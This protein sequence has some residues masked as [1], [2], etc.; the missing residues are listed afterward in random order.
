MRTRTLWSSIAAVVACALGMPGAEDWPQVKYDSER[1][2]NL[3]DRRVSTPL[4]LAGAVPLTDAVLTAPAV[5]DGKVF[6]VDA[7]GTASCID[8]AT[9]AMSWQTRTRGGEWNCNNVSS[10]AVAGGYVHFGTTAGTYYVLRAADGAIVREIRTGDPIFS[11]P[12]AANGAVYFATLGSRVYKVAPDGAVRWVWDYVKEQLKFEGD[13]WSGAAWAARGGRVTWREQF[14][15]TQ[16]IAVHGTMVI[17]PA[18]GPLLWIEDL[19]DRAAVRHIYHEQREDPATLGLSMDGEGAV[20]RQWHQRDNGGRVEILRIADGKI[21]KDFVHGTGSNYDGPESLS[22]SSVSVRGGEVYRTRPEEG[23]GFCRHVQGRPPAP[24][25]GPPSIAAP[26]LAGDKGIVSG[27]DGTLAIV[28]LDG[29]EPPWVFATAFGKA[30]TAPCAVADGKVFFGCDDGHLYVLAPGGAA[31][32]PA[33]GLPLHVIRNPST[34]ALRD[35]RYDWFTSFGDFANTNATRQGI[36]PPFVMRWIRPFKGTAKHFAAFG[37]DR[38]Y[39][40]TAEGQLFAV[41]QETGRLLWRTYSPGVHACFTSPLFHG[42]RLYIPQAGIERA[43][44]RCVDAAT[45]ARIWEAPFTGSPSWNRQQPPIIHEGIVIYLFSSGRYE[46]KQWLFEHQSTF[47]FPPDQKPLLRAWDAKSGK[48]LWTRDFSA[49]GAGGDDAGMCLMDGTL[50]YSCYFGDKAP[51]GVT[52]ALDP[53]TGE[54]RWVTDK[55]ALH[56]GCAL[57]GKDGRLYLGGYN[58][59]EGKVNRVWCLDARDGSLVWASEPVKHAIHVITVRDATLFTHAQYADSYLI[60]RATGKILRTWNKGY[61]CTRFTVAEPYLLGANMDIWDLERDTALV[62]TGP[63]IDV[64]LC[65]GAQV[66]NGRIF[67]T[68]NGAGMQTSMRWGEEAAPPA[69]AP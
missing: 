47:G 12:A 39:T 38:M 6:V 65:V 1:S 15:C 45:G 34:S 8:A 36:R 54:V 41:E 67:Y 29:R 21:A 55:H 7:S 56:A 40:H 27:L 35:A 17:L 37:E 46:P 23:F 33:Q 13:R 66:S 58:P 64:L 48:E 28:P 30:I 42:G 2:G 19:G 51:S 53:A 9:L 60:D 68:T 59:V 3:P 62:S 49:Y 5:K 22:F 25:G 26:V 20:Y 43:F 18:G 63:A 31:R 50:Y 32:P 11:A 52:A 61:R 24:L 69:W 4:G 44:L 16:D 14:C 10:P 57:S